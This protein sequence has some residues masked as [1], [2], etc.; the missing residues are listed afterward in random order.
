MLV[1]RAMMSVCIRE[2]F[3]EKSGQCLSENS[4]K[5]L[6]ALASQSNCVQTM[7]GTE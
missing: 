2:I 4:S 7:T 1:L 5:E 3:W 6:Y